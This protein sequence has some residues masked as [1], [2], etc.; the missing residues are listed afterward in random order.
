VRG[1][2]GRAG[3]GQERLADRRQLH[4]ATGAGEQ[5]R[6]ELALEAADLFADRLLAHVHPGGGPTEMAFLGH[7]DHV[8]QLAQLHLPLPH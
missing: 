3:L 5:R 1:R 4:P 6:P 2:D 8:L 7:R